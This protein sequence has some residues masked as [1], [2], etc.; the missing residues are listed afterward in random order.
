MSVIRFLHTDGLRLGSPVTGL[1]ES[2]DWLRSTATSAVRTAVTNAIEASVA[3][4]CQFLFIAGRLTESH[5][6]LDLAVTWLAAK[7]LV[8]KKHGIRLVLAGHPESDHAALRRLDAILM[9]PGQRLDVSGGPSGST[10]FVV[11]SRTVAALPGALGIEVAS[12]NSERPLAGMAYVAVPA[13]Q[14]SAATNSFDGV[15]AAHDRHLRLSAGCPQAIGPA[16]RGSFGCQLVEADLTRQSMTARFCSTDVIR[17]AQELVTCQPGLQASQLRE[18]LKERSRVF[19]TA[20]RCTMVVEWIIDGQLSA[21]LSD[22]ECLCEPELL[23]VLRAGLHAGHT[24]TW[25]SRIRFS[26]N[27]SVDVA[28]NRSLVTQEFS[29][30]VRDRHVG[31]VLRNLKA[32]CRFIGLPLGGGSET[33]VGLDIL[34]RVA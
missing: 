32:E 12:F 17:F 23:K 34:R 22:D 27:S 21:S 29:T 15:A 28:G 13:I 4:R 19:G 31:N 7:S 24:G 8:L 1:S 14:S 33:A 5:Q 11:S 2:P 30:V 3:G 20:G 10:E 26:E 25:P 9:A 18:L 16:E 6:D